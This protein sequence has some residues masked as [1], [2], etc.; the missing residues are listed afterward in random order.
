V[1]V[2]VALGYLA[3]LATWGLN[4][5][6]APLEDK[7][8]Y[9]TTRVSSDAA[10]RFATLVVQQTNAHYGAAGERTIK[11]TALEYGFVETQRLL[12]HQAFAE[13]G[14]PKWSLLQPYFRWTAI[15][16]MT[17]PGPLE[18]ILNPDLLP[19]E[20]PFTLAHE[21]AHLA[22]YADESE[23]N[24][25]AWLLCVRSDDPF[26]RYSG[27]LEIYGLAVRGVP[28]SARAALPNL[29]EGPRADLRAIG[30]RLSRSSPHARRLAQGAYDSY[31]K[32]HRV[33]EGIL[34]YDA[35]LRLILGT[36]FED[37]WKPVRR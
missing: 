35:A 36:N 33:D 19:V 29:D 22:G 20:L 8:D 18:I 34:S 21:W 15:S 7:I 9:D 6:R 37:D 16:G 11:V 12:G 31:L 5:R 2:L 4:Y 10:I 13:P 28:R 23:A 27:W 3:F 32:A 14:R 1:L 17:V 25:F 30:E 26:I 24:F